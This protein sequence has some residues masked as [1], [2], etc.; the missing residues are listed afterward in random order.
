M[1]NRKD[2]KI[3]VFYIATGD[4]KKLFPSFLES[5]NNFF[6]K[7]KKVVK[8]I[9]DGLDDYD[10]YNKENVYVELVSK[11][12]HY[13]WPIITLY[14]MWHIKENIDFSCDYSCYFNA[15]A[16]IY[17]H[18]EE[19]FDLNKI[20]TSYHSF[21][22]NKELYDPWYAIDI[23]PKSTAYLENKTYEYVQAAFF[24]GPSKLI[25]MMCEDICNMLKQDMNHLLFPRW[26]DE[27]YLNKWCVLNKS[28][29][30]KKYILTA[31]KDEIDLKKFVYL[32]D[33]D[34]YGIKK[35]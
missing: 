8:L 12:N 35:G 2:I 6:P 1:E 16:I 13:P 7:W 5:L 32:Q 24:F 22:K 3:A 34:N 9:S 19:V 18:N 29:V 21:N 14:K 27:S 28:L 33:K 23:D 17:N 4:Y 20:T 26:H 25:Y 31:Y 15:N 10:G 11:I 30:D